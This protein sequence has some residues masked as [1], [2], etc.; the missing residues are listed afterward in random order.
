MLDQLEGHVTEAGQK[1]WK[2][3]QSLGL[4][5]KKSESYRYVRLSDLYSSSFEAPSRSE[6]PKGELTFVNGIF[7]SDLSSP[8]EGV[9][10]LPLSQGALTYRAILSHRLE[11]E[12]AS[13]KDPFALLNRAIHREGLFLYIPSKLECE[14]T[15]T[16]HYTS[17]MLCAPRIHLVAGRESSTKLRLKHLLSASSACITSYLDLALDERA[18]LQLIERPEKGEPGWHFETIRATLKRSS[19]LSTYTHVEGG[20][21]TR[22]DYHIQLQAP[23]AEA[24]LYGLAELKAH[25]HHHT[26]VLMEHQAPHCHSLQHFKSVLSGPSRAS[27][28]GKI[29]VHPEAQKTDAYQMNNNLLLTPHAQA[30]SKP[31]LEIF[32][33]DVKASHGSTTGQLDEEAIFYL[34]SRGLKK[35]AAYDLLVNGF[36]QEILQKI[37]C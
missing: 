35:E 7:R 18:A 9:V 13:E 27:F 25:R 33:D 19:R 14:L 36:C 6:A 2:R 11:Q 37:P 24:T 23:D 20:I 10:A 17:N 31:N 26:H 1:A 4:P 5:T 15:V 8:P 12:L 22:Q 32:A 30:Y 21:T 16:F 28:E 3:L 34:T 29:Y